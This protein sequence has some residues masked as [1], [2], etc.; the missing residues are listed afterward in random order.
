MK[1]KKRDSAIIAQRKLEGTRRRS[2][3]KS[4]KPAGRTRDIER[5]AAVAQRRQSQRDSARKNLNRAICRKNQLADGLKTQQLR[6]QKLLDNPEI[7]DEQMLDRFHDYATSRLMD[8]ATAWTI[9]GYRCFR[10]LVCATGTTLAKVGP[11][12]SK[13][14]QLLALHSN[15]DNWSL[16]LGIVYKAITG[17]HWTKT[18]R[19][20]PGRKAA[21]SAVTALAAADEHEQKLKDANRPQQV[22]FDESAKQ[23]MIALV[24]WDAQLD[25]PEIIS[26]GV[27]RLRKQDGSTIEC[28]VMEH[29]EHVHKVNNG[30]SDNCPGMHGKYNGAMLKGV[31]GLSEKSSAFFR[32]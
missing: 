12:F 18:G 15:C 3:V 23:L 19:K 7:T 25:S 5:K 29:V 14:P 31:H 22:L 28:H 21:R 16:L 11:G 26:A 2:N 27:Q 4:S 24:H 13:L 30:L 17:R 10:D 9:N 20:L 6:T 32:N 8:S 1:T